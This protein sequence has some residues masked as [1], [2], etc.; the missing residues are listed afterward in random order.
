M[1]LS[2]FGLTENILFLVGG[3]SLS[4]WVVEQ[5]YASVKKETGLEIQLTLI[6]LLE[7]SSANSSLNHEAWREKHLDGH[8]NLVSASSA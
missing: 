5:L 2:N 4:V 3:V 8:P 6:G 7:P 1:V